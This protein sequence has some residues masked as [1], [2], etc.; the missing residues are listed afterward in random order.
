MMTGEYLYLTWAQ[1]TQPAGTGYAVKAQT[2]YTIKNEDIVK[3]IVC[4]QKLIIIGKLL[5]QLD[6]KKLS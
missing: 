6:L 2:L 4:L 1:I 5:D 3:D